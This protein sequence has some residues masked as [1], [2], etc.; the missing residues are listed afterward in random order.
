[1]TNPN[2]T[3]IDASCNSAKA[4]FASSSL[5][6]YLPDASVITSVPVGY[7]VLDADDKPPF[8]MTRL[9]NNSQLYTHNTCKLELAIMFSDIIYNEKVDINNS[10]ISRTPGLSYS[11][12]NGYCNDD[13]IYFTGVD[14]T[15]YRKAGSGISTRIVLS[16]IPSKPSQN[17][18]VEWFGYVI[19]DITEKVT[20]GINSDDAS[21][22]WIGN[23]AIYDYNIENADI[24]NGGAHG[25]INK[26][27]SIDLSAGEI[28]PIRIHYGQA[29]GGTDSI[30][31]VK[32]SSKGTQDNYN[33]LYTLLKNNR[34]Y[35][36]I[37]LYYALVQNTLDDTSKGLFQCYFYKTPVINSDSF[38]GGNLVKHL[39]SSSTST[40][41]TRIKYE[42]IWTSATKFSSKTG[43]S[44]I[45]DKYGL[46]I[47]NNRIPSWN[48][49]SDYSL[50]LENIDNRVTLN[51][52]RSNSN[53]YTTVYPFYNYSYTDSATSKK[54]KN[55][56]S[57]P[58]IKSN[59]TIDSS[60]PLISN[61]FKY[62]LTIKD[63][64]LVL[65]RAKT[66]IPKKNGDLT[67]RDLTY[68]DDD[69]KYLYNLRC[70]PR[71]NK[72]FYVNQKNKQLQF[73]PNDSN[74]LKSTGNF[75]TFSNYIPADT[76]QVQ[77]T[78]STSCQKDCSNNTLCNGVYA[79]YKNGNKFCQNLLTPTGNIV[80]SN[81]FNDRQLDPN[82]T[83]GSLYMKEKSIQMTSVS[84]STYDMCGNTFSSINQYNTDTMQT[85]TIGNTLSNLNR[86]ASKDH[87]VMDC[88]AKLNKFFG[89]PTAVASNT[90][91]KQKESFTQY[92]S[93]NCDSNNNKDCKSFTTTEKIDPLI[94]T[95]S[96]YSK[97][98]QLMNTNNTTFSNNLTT[99]ISTYTDLSNSPIYQF[100]KDHNDFNNKK[101]SVL[102][103]ANDDLDE[104]LVQ[105]NNMYIIGTITTATLLITAILLSSS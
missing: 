61:D 92:N 14:D 33:I 15:D 85:H 49:P 60:H 72:I 16:D 71:L 90:M 22:L 58:T 84:G 88:S 3:Q 62:K 17:F 35:K 101:K 70:D 103:V 83:S 94:K 34:V 78:K 40:S 102:E 87:A 23:K 27:I 12:V 99:H 96:D 53:S 30:L 10:V 13:H 55:Q 39:D 18:S 32:S 20:F 75:I 57:R 52:K 76:T 91:A 63:G 50:W 73:L 41:T 47:N 44:A 68:T 24:K 56:G 11:L 54:W 104:L 38:K 77:S 21:Y 42:T 79:Y 26:Y 43:T 48:A 66:I 86:D 8:Q 74:L 100:S 69:T 4:M 25:M 80:P 7:S 97:A 37:Q 45:I 98:L 93:Y 29:G 46:K 9:G 95:A 65:V 59:E 36:Q 5:A 28:Y 31:S 82:I 67:Y 64:F 19:P 1:M 51:M 2:S 89:S 81:M 105:Q 6:R